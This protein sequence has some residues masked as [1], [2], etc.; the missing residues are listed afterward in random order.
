MFSYALHHTLARPLTPV[1]S[2]CPD[3]WIAR[4][5]WDKEEMT[6]ILPPRPPLSASLS[7]LLAPA[8]GIIFSNTSGA[9]ATLPCYKGD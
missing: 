4:V 3:H 2:L 5:W 7:A 1:T 9:L 8:R 6:L